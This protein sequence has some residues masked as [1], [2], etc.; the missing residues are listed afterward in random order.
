MTNGPQC[1]L[2]KKKWAAYVTIWARGLI[3]KKTLPKRHREIQRAF[4]VIGTGW[5]LPGET[6]KGKKLPPGSLARE[7]NQ[8]PKGKTKKALF[9][10]RKEK[11][12]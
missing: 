1:V 5:N 8:A 6:K 2:K 7:I 11:K 10:R 9:A 12:E 3:Y 4:P